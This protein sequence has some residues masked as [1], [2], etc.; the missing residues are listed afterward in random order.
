MTVVELAAVVVTGM[1]AES[2]VVMAVRKIEPDRI[3]S[4][5]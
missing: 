1:V 4:G 5:A 3:K 2:V